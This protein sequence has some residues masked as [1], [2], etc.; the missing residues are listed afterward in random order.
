MLGERR[1]GT[2]REV[3]SRCHQV[4]YMVLDHG[5][6]MWMCPNCDLD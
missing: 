3:C 1:G 6:N 5:L 2:K 4:Q